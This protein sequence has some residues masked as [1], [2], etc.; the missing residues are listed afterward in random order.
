MPKI[1]AIGSEKIWVGDNFNWSPVRF[2]HVSSNFFIVGKPLKELKQSTLLQA[3]LTHKIKKD[4][5]G[6][7]LDPLQIFKTKGRG[8]DPYISEKSI[9]RP[10]F[11]YLGNFT[12]SDVVFK[13]IAE[14]LA[15]LASPH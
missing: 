13:Q 4:F 8:K 9:I 6:Y 2:S 15:F 3:I 12:I 7:I 10:T 11:S 1:L 14:Y 5:S